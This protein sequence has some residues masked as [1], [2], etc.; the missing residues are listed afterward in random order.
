MVLK[1]NEYI[2]NVKNASY[3][4]DK[5]I[6][7]IQ[8]IL[9]Y[10]LNTKDLEKRYTFK[11]KIFSVKLKDIYIVEKILNKYSEVLEK[12]ELLMTYEMKKFDYLDTCSFHIYIKS[13]KIERVKPPQ[14]VYHTSN[15]NRRNMILKDGLIPMSENW[16]ADLNYKPAI[17]ASTDKDSLFS[18]YGKDVWKID[19]SKIK[20]I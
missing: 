19:T 11:F 9:P 13:N 17:F 20:N 14:F 3:F 15:P 10:T 5:I 2:K 4:V 8:N 1:L 16:G 7:E 12:E 6:N 18:P